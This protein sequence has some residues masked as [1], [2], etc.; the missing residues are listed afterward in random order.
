[1]KS[2]FRTKAILFLLFIS[3]QSFADNS[4]SL[5]T[6]ATRVNGEALVYFILMLFIAYLFFRK[7]LP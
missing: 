6:F 3:S 2:I 5:Q 4:E 1:M 7:P